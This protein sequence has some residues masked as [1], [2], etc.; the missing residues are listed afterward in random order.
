[1]LQ[2]SPF[3]IGMLVCFGASW[4][5]NLYKTWKMK[6]STGKSLGFLWLVEI[7]Y[8]SGTLHKIV[9]RYDAVIFLYILNALMV[10]TDILLCYYYGS[11]SAPARAGADDVR[12]G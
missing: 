3:E 8:I 1:M 2:M 5:F 6:S 11:K 12:V 7:G 10:L 4:P 9:Y